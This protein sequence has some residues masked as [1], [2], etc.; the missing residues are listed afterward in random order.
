MYSMV[1]S[2]NRRLNNNF[3]LDLIAKSYL[4]K[5]LDSLFYPFSKRQMDRRQTFKD[6][7]RQYPNHQNKRIEKESNGTNNPIKLV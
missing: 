1:C 5:F 3:K 7:R 6:Y 4:R 2:S